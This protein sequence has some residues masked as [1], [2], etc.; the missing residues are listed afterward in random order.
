MKAFGYIVTSGINGKFLQKKKFS[1]KG[2]NLPTI[3]FFLKK[4]TE[5]HNDFDYQ[6]VTNFSHVYSDRI[7]VH[8]ALNILIDHTIKNIFLFISVPKSESFFGKIYRSNV[9]KWTITFLN[10]KYKVLL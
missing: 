2:H 1:V 8:V 10:F 6:R 5:L 7:D 9:Q 4:G 3:A